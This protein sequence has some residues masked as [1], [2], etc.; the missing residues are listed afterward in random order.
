MA[1]NFV[2]TTE[3]RTSK[4][5]ALK[6]EGVSKSNI[7]YIN[8]SHGKLRANLGTIMDGIYGSKR[9]LWR[10]CNI[11]WDGDDVWYDPYQY[12][13]NTVAQW[14]PRLQAVLDAFPEVPEGYDTWY[15]C[16]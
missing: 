2:P 7:I 12:D 16:E 9:R 10:D 5:P 8:K 4:K 3:P 6:V 15:H 11:R 13:F 14:I 1:V